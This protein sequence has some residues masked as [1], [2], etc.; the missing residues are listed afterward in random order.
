MEVEVKKTT[1]SFVCSLVMASFAVLA[2]AGPSVA[3]PKAKKLTF[4]QAWKVCKKKLDKEQ[5]A[6]TMLQGNERFIKGGACMKD[7]G[8][9]L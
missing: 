8:Y 4:E 2:L 6:G 7:L 9:S 3:A 1:K 5:A